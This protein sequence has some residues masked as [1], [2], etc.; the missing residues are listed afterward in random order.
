MDSTVIV[1]VTTAGYKLGL[2]VPNAE[3]YE[4]LQIKSSDFPEDFVFGA[5]TSAAQIEGSPNK[6]GKGQSDWEYQAINFP[7]S[8]ANSSKFLQGIDS[9]K[10]YK[11]D[12]KL[13]KKLGVDSYRLSL[14][15]TRIL[16]SNNS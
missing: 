8:I 16:P 5:A 2:E 4:E 6:D 9:Y 13:V 12:V 1:N 10:R 11:G 3:V 7:D 14:A 15:W